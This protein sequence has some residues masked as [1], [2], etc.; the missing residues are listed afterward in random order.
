MI[1]VGECNAANMSYLAVYLHFLR[2]EGGMLTL[3]GNVSY[4]AVLGACGFGVR[5][6]GHVMD[7]VM[8]DMHLDLKWGDCL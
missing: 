6:N 4:P 2:F 3:E 7:A 8:T 1:R 5:V